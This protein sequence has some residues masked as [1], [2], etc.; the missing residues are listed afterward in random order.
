MR[1]Y[2]ICR[3]ALL[4]IVMVSAGAA[5]PLFAQNA[6]ACALLTP[7]DI[8][9]A[10][11]LS[12]GSGNA[13]KA[14]PGVLG[15]CTWLGSGNTKLIVTLADAQHMQLTVEAQQQTGGT[16]LPDLGSKAVG[17]KGAPFTGGGYIV[18]VLDS[19]GGF[20][21]SILGAD[22]NQAR[23]VALAKIVEGRR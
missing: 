11:G 10:T 19:K 16:V 20:G 23:V 6:N 3:L 12:V 7:A 8:S 18:S 4:G 15:R 14:I 13:G 22:G 1:R 5:R 17:I 9:K 21:V 2:I